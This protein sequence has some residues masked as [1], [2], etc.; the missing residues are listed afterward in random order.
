MCISIVDFAEKINEL[1][2]NSTI[3]K[4]T[5]SEDSAYNKKT[6]ANKKRIRLIYQSVYTIV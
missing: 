1:Y 6:Y 3:Q 2:I 4:L 5:I